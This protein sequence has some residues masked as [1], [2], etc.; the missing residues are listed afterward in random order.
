M[1]C[2]FEGVDTSGKS[3]QIAL[4]KKRFPEA[5][6]TKEPGGTPL[7]ERLR[8]IIL[9]HGAQSFKSELF[10]FLADRAEH[11]RE[12]IAPNQ[13][14]LILSD[15]G[16]VSGIAYAMANHPDLDESF[17]IEQ[18]LFALDGHLPDQVFLFLTTEELIRQRMQTKEED[19][20]EKRGI[21]YL[22]RV[23]KNMEHIVK[24]LDLPCHYIDASDPIEA[25]HQNIIK[26]L[27]P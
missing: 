15:R 27:Q 9:H 1:Y 17:L 10:L 6:V 5:I 23:Q 12:V 24:R 7:G 13:K 26:G 18:N 25:I 20:I 22:M 19:M 3:T 2:L 4:L 14:K 21:D 8:E 16:F 11:T